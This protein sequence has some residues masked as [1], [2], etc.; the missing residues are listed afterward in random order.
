LCDVHSD[1]LTAFGA[2]E[3]ALRKAARHL[4]RPSEGLPILTR[5]GLDIL[6][7]M[8]VTTVLEGYDQEDSRVI[9]GWIKGGV[10][11]IPLGR[12][13]C[14]EVLTACWR[15]GKA[16]FS[17]E[18]A[19]FDYGQN[20]ITPKRFGEIGFDDPQRPDPQRA[21]EYIWRRVYQDVHG[22]QAPTKLSPAKIEDLRA[23]LDL[24]Q[25]EKRRRLRL[26][27]DRFDLDEAFVLESV[28]GAIHRAVP[29]IHLILIDS[30]ISAHPSIFVLP[31]SELAAGI[32]SCLKTLQDLP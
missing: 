16:E 30:G 23:W 28:L 19:R 11:H 13:P 29:Q 22:E 12:S 14:V 17:T 7:W 27:V 5:Y 31:A 25:R 15:R 24:Q 6:G 9:Q 18:P 26:V 8:A 2:L 1:F 4:A 32:Y 3:A 10:F 21:V 20:D